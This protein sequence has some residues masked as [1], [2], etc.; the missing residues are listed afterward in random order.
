MKH[1][2]TWDKKKDMRI[3]AILSFFFGIVVKKD[4]FEWIWDWHNRDRTKQKKA[5]EHSDGEREW[6]KNEWQDREG[7]EKG[8]GQIQFDSEAKEKAREGNW[9]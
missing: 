1:W 9:G 7:R 5:W 8:N 2:E 6:Q 3:E 4:G